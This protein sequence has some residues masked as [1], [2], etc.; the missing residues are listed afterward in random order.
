MIRTAIFCGSFDPIHIGHA[1]LANHV[2]QS[3]LVDE[4]WLMPSR[5]N[6]LKT[7][8]PPAADCHRLAMCRLVAARCSGVRADDY[9]M[10]LPAP[11]Y[12]YDTLC[13]LREDYPER[14]FL[15]LIG[16]D[17]WLCFNKWRNHD[18]IVR[19]FE[20]LIYPRPGYDVSPE[21]LPESVK[22]LDDVPQVLLSSSFIRKGLREGRNMNFL[23]PTD[24]LD[25]IKKER[26]YE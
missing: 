10:C 5:V 26:L 1:L 17:N 3:G 2:A 11:S 12:T 16:S 24:V 25:Y 7:A 20:L 15:L 13:R 22:L 14:S 6:P 9:E 23:L 8:S 18:S 21:S 19:E 4:L